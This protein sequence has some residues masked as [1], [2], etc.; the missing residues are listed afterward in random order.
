MPVFKNIFINLEHHFCPCPSDKVNLSWSLPVDARGRTCL[1][2]TCE[3]CKAEILIPNDSF[4]ASFRVENPNP[5]S[6]PK[7]APN[8]EE[9]EEKKGEGKIGGLSG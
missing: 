9:G 2:L 6:K 4:K 1:K 3:T 8:S 5:P 7:E